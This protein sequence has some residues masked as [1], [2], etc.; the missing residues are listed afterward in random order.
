MRRRG[1]AQRYLGARRNW[2]RRRQQSCSGVPLGLGARSRQ[3]LKAVQRKRW[4]ARRLQELTAVDPHV[5]LG[6]AS[7]RCRGWDLGRR[8]VDE[9]RVDAA[10]H[11]VAA[12]RQLACDRDGRDLAVVTLLDLCV[13]VVVGAAQVRRVL[14][15]FV[16]RPAQ[17]LGALAR[18]VAPARA[19]ASPSASS[20][21]ERG[22]CSFSQTA[23][24]RRPASR[25]SRCVAV[26]ASH[27]L[28]LVPSVA[29]ALS[30]ASAS[31]GGRDTDRFAR[32]AVA[33]DGSTG[34]RTGSAAEPPV[35]RHPHSEGTHDLGDDA[36]YAACVET[37][38]HGFRVVEARR[39]ADGVG[40]RSSRIRPGGHSSSAA[41]RAGG[42]R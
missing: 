19:R 31:S 5:V 14:R 2:C 37:D 15:G 41:A 10:Q 17:R 9:F 13:V 30:I 29:A 38:D 40:P 4:R 35:V 42:T 3:C 20:S 26:S 7:R 39:T 25:R 12:P 34:G 21:G 32:R 8:R 1:G 16:E 36:A 28:K 6:C 27:A 24:P 11:V 18:Q 22:P 33:D 23:S